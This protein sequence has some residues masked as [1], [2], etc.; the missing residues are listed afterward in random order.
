MVLLIR[1]CDIVCYQYNRLTAKNMAWR[2]IQPKT[3][4]PGKILLNSNVQIINSFNA[5]PSDSDAS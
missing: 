2:K 1:G 4:R 5:T 3:A